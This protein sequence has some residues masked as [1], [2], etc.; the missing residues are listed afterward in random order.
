MSQASLRGVFMSFIAR[1]SESCFKSQAFF[2]EVLLGDGH[3][4]LKRFQATSIYLRGVAK[5]GSEAVGC[6][7]R[8]LGG[9]LERY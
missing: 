4:S 5:V 3:L 1:L 7:E 6:V 8:Q 2:L 9:L